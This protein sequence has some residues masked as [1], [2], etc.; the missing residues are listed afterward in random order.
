MDFLMC[1]YSTPLYRQDTPVVIQRTS[2]QGR[3]TALW[4]PPYACQGYMEGDGKLKKSVMYSVRLTP[5]EYEALKSKCEKS[6]IEVSEFVRSAMKG[7]NVSVIEGIPEM[8]VALNRIGNNINQITRNHNSKLYREEDRELLSAYMKKL[9]LLV[10]EVVDSL[11][12][13]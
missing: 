2:C 11:G 10:K 4:N 12:N 7:K 1:Q 3:S 8:I 6:G 13:Q 9:N 5:L